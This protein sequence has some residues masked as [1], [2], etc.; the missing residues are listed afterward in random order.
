M[1][2]WNNSKSPVFDP[3]PLNRTNPEPVLLNAYQSNDFFK[4][5]FTYE[6]FKSLPRKD[7]FRRKGLENMDFVD[8]GEVRGTHWSGFFRQVL[9]NPLVE[10]TPSHQHSFPHK[11]FMK[12]IIETYG[13]YKLIR[14]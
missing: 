12:S 1:V 8:L 4:N 14:D 6:D 13:I 3:L 10:G 5:N 9:K 2:N 7:I 11:S